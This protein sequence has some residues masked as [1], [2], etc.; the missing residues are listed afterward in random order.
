MARRLTPAT[1][2]EFWER[3]PEEERPITLRGQ[4]VATLDELLALRA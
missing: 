1:L 3:L 4:E 2:R